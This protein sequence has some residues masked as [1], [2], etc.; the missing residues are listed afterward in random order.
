MPIDASEMLQYLPEKIIDRTLSDYIYHH[1]DHLNRCIENELFTSAYQHLHILYMCFVYIQL[2]RISKE[3]NQE[4][5]FCWI[6]FPNQEKD[7]LKDSNSPLSFSRINEK[8]VF[9]FFRLVGFNDGDIGEISS[10]V[11]KRN[12]HFHANGKI[13]FNLPEDFEEEVLQYFNKMEKIVF[14]ELDFLEELYMSV[15]NDFEMDYEITH[16][17]IESY[18]FL[19]YYFSVFELK[20]IAKNKNDQFSRFII[21]EI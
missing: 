18:L 3:K 1:M 7:F 16:D 11:N 4:F 20:N 8:T 15:I 13:F 10:L 5:N 2:L 19:P 9:R 12:E 17:D 6:G 21:N 14:K